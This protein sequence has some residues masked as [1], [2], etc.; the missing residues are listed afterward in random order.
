MTFCFKQ[1]SYCHSE[2]HLT[3]T[4]ADTSDALTNLWYTTYLTRSI[5]LQ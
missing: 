1:D 3:L 5:H 4:S 2:N